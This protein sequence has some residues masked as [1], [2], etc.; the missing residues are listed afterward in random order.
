MEA[1][2]DLLPQD[3]AAFGRYVSRS[4][5]GSFTTR[6]WRQLRKE[7]FGLLVIVQFALVP[8]VLFFTVSDAKVWAL[9]VLIVIGQVVCLVARLFVLHGS[10]LGLGT[11]LRKGHDVEI[12]MAIGPEWFSYA[13]RFVETAWRWTEF[14][15]IAL[16]QDHA[17]FFISPREAYILPRRAF[18]NEDAYRE[19]VH[20]ARRYHE[21]A[22]VFTDN[23]YQD[24][25]ETGP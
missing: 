21:A 24:L 16:T 8:T 4:S 7:V 1:R 19:F 2:F 14:E 3:R 22:K 23:V 15:R 9:S 6:L 11:T 12:R 10:N 17:F 5:H 13:N 20:A 18:V 25:T